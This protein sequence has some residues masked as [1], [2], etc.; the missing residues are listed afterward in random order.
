MTWP[1]PAGQP[2]AIVPHSPGFRGT[3][4]PSKGQPCFAVTLRLVGIPSALSAIARYGQPI[5]KTRL[6]PSGRSR[7]PQGCR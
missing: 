7:R 5:L 1:C 2:D 3:N 6:S 4:V